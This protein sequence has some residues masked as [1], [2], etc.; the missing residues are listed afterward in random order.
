MWIRLRIRNR[1][2]AAAWALSLGLAGAGAAWA[3]S[4]MIDAHG[5]YPAA[6]AA[7]L[8]PACGGSS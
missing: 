2:A 7:A 1:P 8:P 5:H 6:D 4:P 3:A